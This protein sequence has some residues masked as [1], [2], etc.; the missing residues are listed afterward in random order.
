[1]F[2]KS[3]YRCDVCTKNKTCFVYSEFANSFAVCPECFI[4]ITK[5]LK[6]LE[7][8]NIKNQACDLC[9]IEKK[10]LTNISEIMEDSFIFHY[11]ICKECMQK[12]LNEAT[13]NSG[14]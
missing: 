11:F 2:V 7:N 14:I 13:E 4:A 8:F 3:N 6:N 9:E 1:M 5:R 10:D 12:I